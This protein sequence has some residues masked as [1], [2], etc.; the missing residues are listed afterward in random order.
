MNSK[1]VRDKIME[2]QRTSLV[3]LAAIARER[4][5]Y[6]C[7][8]VDLCDS[9]YLAVEF[10]LSLRD[11]ARYSDHPVLVTIGNPFIE[12]LEYGDNEYITFEEFL[13]LTPEILID[14]LYHKKIKGR[15]DEKE[16]ESY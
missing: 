9:T 8:F 11:G 15:C 10:P 13:I 12:G 3:R 4:G 7:L 2:I 5:E 1:S 16:K 14:K 6:E